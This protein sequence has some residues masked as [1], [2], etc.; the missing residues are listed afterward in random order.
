MKECSIFKLEK[1]GEEDYGMRLLIVVKG[2][3]KAREFEGALTRILLQA[4]KPFYKKWLEDKDSAFKDVTK[5]VALKQEAESLP[6]SEIHNFCGGEVSEVQKL[7]NRYS[8]A[9]LNDFS[10]SVFDG[11]LHDLIAADLD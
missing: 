3:N 6:D 4:M 1:A 9:Q 11:D 5:N 10:N 8:T 7:L 2:E